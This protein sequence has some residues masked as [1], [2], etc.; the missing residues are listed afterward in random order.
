MSIYTQRNIK[1]KLAKQGT[2]NVVES[3]I[4][5]LEKL[6]AKKPEIK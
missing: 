2:V 1:R 3:I 5:I 6:Q 4:I